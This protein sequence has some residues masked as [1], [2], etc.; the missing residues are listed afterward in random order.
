MQYMQ[1][2]SFGKIYGIYILLDGGIIVVLYRA[3]V[4]LNFSNIWY[5]WPFHIVDLFACA[6]LTL[7][8]IMFLPI[9]A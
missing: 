2:Y 7:I 6:V 9:A 4:K 8:L 3:S 1:R 5:M